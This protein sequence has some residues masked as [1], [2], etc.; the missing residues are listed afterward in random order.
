MGQRLR[1]GEVEI[2]E[3]HLIL[4]DQGILRGNRLLDLDNHVRLGIDLFNR[5]A[6]LGPD[7]EVILI[8]KPAPESR[9]TLHD[10]GVLSTGQFKHA[11]GRHA[12]P[13]LGWFNLGRDSNGHG[14]KQLSET[15]T[16]LFDLDQTTHNILTISNM[17]T[18]YTDFERA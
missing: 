6:N 1:R 3:D 17:C 18:W 12:H 8:G 9:T 7:L 16:P 4:S 10:D 2:G 15:G 14:S 13:A 5:G 11:S